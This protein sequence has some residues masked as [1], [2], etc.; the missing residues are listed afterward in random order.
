MGAGGKFQLRKE[1]IAYWV[2]GLAGAGRAKDQKLAQAAVESLGLKGRVRVVSDAEVALRGAFAEQSGIILISGTGSICFGLDPKGQVVRAGGWGYLLGDEGSGYY[3]G[4]QAIL[5][6]LR[7]YDGRGP[8][9][10]LRAALEERFQIDGIEKIIHLIY[11]Q[12]L[13]REE[14][15]ALAPL[16]FEHAD[17]GDKVAQHIIE[18]ASQ[19]LGQ[20]AL[21]VARRMGLQGRPIRLACTG[22]VFKRKNW[23]LEG[24]REVLT[25]LSDDVSIESPRFPP[26][27]GALFLAYRAIGRTLSDTILRNLEGSLPS[28]G[29]TSG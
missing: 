16:V 19:E 4:H 28:T 11:G 13:S 24:I 6:A 21:A 14:I 29:K 1:Q 3:I 25:T 15:A 7:D 5:A 9:T 12:R 17:A 18:R 8:S 10:S 27:V 23:L 2:L 20:L 22:S 26:P